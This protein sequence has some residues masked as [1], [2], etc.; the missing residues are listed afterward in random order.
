MSAKTFPDP[1][2]DLNS[3]VLGAF[4]FTPVLHNLRGSP[5]RTIATQKSLENR[6]RSIPA[7]TTCSNPRTNPL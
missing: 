3:A 2:V 6:N 4:L 7:L 5:S 1:N